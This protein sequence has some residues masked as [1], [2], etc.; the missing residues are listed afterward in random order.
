MATRDRVNVSVLAPLGGALVMA[1]VSAA[2]AAQEP[3]RAP[4]GADDPSARVARISYVLGNVSFQP[5]GDSGWSLATVNYPV[6][7]GDRIFADRGDRAELQVG[8]VTVRL[9]EGTDLTMTSLTDQLVQLG[10]TQGT[11]HVSIYRMAPDDSVEVDTPRGALTLQA[12]GEY[13][14]DLPAGD[15]PM[16]VAVVRGDLQWTAGGVAQ[17]LRGGQAIQLSGIDPIQVSSISLPAKDDFDRWSADRDRRVSASPSAQY[18]SRDIP[19]YEDLD[20]YGAWQTDAQYGPVWYPAGVRADW[21]PYRYGRWVWIEPWGWTWVENE[22]WGYAPFHYGRW[23]NVGARWGWLP[24]PVEVRSYYAPAL[25][26]FVGGSSFSAGVSAW[27]PLGPG[28]PYYPWYH[29]GDDYGRRVNV[30]NIRN[31]TDINRINDATYINRITYR[32]R[33]EATT[34]VPTTIFQSGQVVGRRAIPVDRQASLGTVIMPHPIAMPSPRAAAGGV[35][36]E[37]GPKMRRPDWVAAPAPRPAPPVTR[38]QP[39]VVPRSVPAPQ[40]EQPLRGNRPGMEPRSV[41]AP[42]P[43]PP[44]SRYQ[45]P[46]VP[47]NVP[48]PAP[49]LITRRAP[50]PQDPPFPQRQRA[51]QPDAGRPLEPQQMQN[52]RSGQPAGPRRDPEYPPHPAPAARAAPPARQASPAAKPAQQQ[53]ARK[54]ERK[55]GP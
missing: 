51:M 1:A 31:V 32:N 25:V 15:D 5:S 55:P 43:V 38:G 21:V 53:P 9:S 34:A 35:P 12:E 3:M 13:R 50:P 26:V 49:V 44:V 46:A 6:T 10:L 54:G 19:G 37:G 39:L 28:E 47:E 29:H 45:P 40:P 17:T 52:L 36:A 11:L 2:L 33:Q 24:G 48:A 22:R 8:Q 23:V 20:D 14:I 27:F 7:T 18:V 4:A 41:P 30:T 42:Q 16:V